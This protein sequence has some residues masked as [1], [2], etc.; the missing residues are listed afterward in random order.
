MQRGGIMSLASL[1]SGCLCVDPESFQ[2]KPQPGTRL[3]GGMDRR[4]SSRSAGGK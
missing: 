2:V 4:Q 3:G 1:F